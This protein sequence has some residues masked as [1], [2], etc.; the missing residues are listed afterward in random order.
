MG[1]STLISPKG[2]AH[3]LFGELHE[4]A[5]GGAYYCS[6]FL[7]IGQHEPFILHPK[8]TGNA[9]WST[10]SAHLYFPI[11]ARDEEAYLI[12]KL[13]VFTL[14]TSRI[15]VFQRVFS[16]LQLIDLDQHNLSMIVSPH[17]HPKEQIFDLN[18][19]PI[20]QQFTWTRT[21]ARMYAIQERM[22][23]ASGA[24]WYA[25]LEGRDQSSG[26]SFIMTNVDHSNDVVNPNR[27]EDIYLTGASPADMDFIA[28][29]RQDI[30]FLLAEIARL[31][32]E[33]E[34]GKK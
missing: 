14:E 15:Q 23:N 2:D 29:A 33:L 32:L 26:S 8:S 4:Q 3:V 5:M 11:W 10:D 9:L 7:Q 25:I 12:H 19:E 22:Q 13:A 27:G 6:M 21:D 16:V 18:A 17:W 31:K 34:I 24:G 28:H 1:E 20:E 30:P